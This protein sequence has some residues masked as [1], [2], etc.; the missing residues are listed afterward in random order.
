MDGKPI[1]N[2]NE[3]VDN[4]NVKGKIG[5]QTIGCHELS[6]TLQYYTLLWSTNSC[7]ILYK[8]I[9]LAVGLEIIVLTTQAQA[10]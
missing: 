3:F 5:T 7:W 8:L 9:K 6:V 4:K 1:V 10:R 2:K